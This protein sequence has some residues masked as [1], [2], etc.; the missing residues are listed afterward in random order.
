MSLPGGF[1]QPFDSIRIGSR[2]LGIPLPQ[3]QL[4]VDIVPFGSRLEPVEALAYQLALVL[5]LTIFP[6]LITGFTVA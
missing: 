3:D 2:L 1:L 4:R 6:P 5:L